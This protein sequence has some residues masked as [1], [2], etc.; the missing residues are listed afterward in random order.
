M[1][2]YLVCLG[3]KSFLEI[4]NFYFKAGL[5]RMV[6]L[7]LD[8]ALVVVVQSLSCVQLFVTPW[9]VAYQASPFLE[10][11]QI[12]NDFYNI[13]VYLNETEVLKLLILT[14]SICYLNFVTSP[15]KTK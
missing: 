2:D 5:T 6:S 3:L 9:T 11:A 15:I 8:E 4:K 12:H 7:F 13:K 1:T 10:L 14:A